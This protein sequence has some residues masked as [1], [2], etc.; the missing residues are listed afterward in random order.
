[1]GLAQALESDQGTLSDSIASDS[2][3]EFCS[4]Q[5]IGPLSTVDQLEP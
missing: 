5:W 3:S 1:M 2:L 4:D